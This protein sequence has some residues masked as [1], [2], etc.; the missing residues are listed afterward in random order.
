MYNTVG[1]D[2]F[3]VHY[4]FFE[5]STDSVCFYVYTPTKEYLRYLKDPS[6]APLQ[7]LIRPSTGLRKG[8]TKERNKGKVLAPFVTSC[9]TV[10]AP[11]SSK[12]E[13]KVKDSVF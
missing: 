7:D 3:F 5:D 4:T 9:S 6:N 2:F 12:A 10:S 13:Q 8:S 1:V 11:N